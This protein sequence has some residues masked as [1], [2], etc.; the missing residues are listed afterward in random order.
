MGFGVACLDALPAFR[1]PEPFAT[2]RSKGRRNGYP[3]PLSESYN[4]APVVPP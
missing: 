4:P 3:D 1:R 2:T